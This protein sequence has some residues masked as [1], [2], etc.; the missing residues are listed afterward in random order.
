MATDWSTRDAAI[1]YFER[2]VKHLKQVGDDD[3]EVY[4]AGLHALRRSQDHTAIQTKLGEVK[5]ENEFLWTWIDRM[6]RGEVSTPECLNTIT[7]RPGAPAWVLKYKMPV[8]LR[9][10]DPTDSTVDDLR[11]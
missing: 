4:E 10:T 11:T 7:H 3:A 5:A 8:P 2:L 9:P 1:P 6:V